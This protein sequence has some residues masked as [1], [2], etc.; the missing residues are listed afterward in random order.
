[1]YIILFL[2]N[3][4]ITQWNHHYPTQA[5][6]TITNG[7]R[8]LAVTAVG[9][10]INAAVR[11]AY[12]AVDLISFE[13]KH[14]RTDIAHRGSSAPIRLGVLGSTRG[15]ALQAVIDAIESGKLNARITLILR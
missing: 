10:T 12:K 1:M 15:T 5:D 13:G 11:N 8:V 9:A 6:N 4:A 14:A 7:G 2:L 3:S